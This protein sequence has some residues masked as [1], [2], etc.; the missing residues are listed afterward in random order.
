MLNVSIL[1]PSTQPL[2]PAELFVLASLRAAPLHGYGLV[3]EVAAR[4]QGRIRIRPGNL[5]RVLDR[6]LDR[7]LIEVHERASAG[8]ERRTYY[9]ITPLGRRVAQ[10]EARLLAGVIGELLAT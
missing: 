1:D 7:G 9:R 10:A 8:D 3:Q 4:S 6:L 5:Y 2:K